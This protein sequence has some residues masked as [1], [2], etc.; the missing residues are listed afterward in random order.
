MVEGVSEPQPGTTLGVVRYRV[1]RLRTDLITPG[2]DAPA[3]LRFAP[4]GDVSLQLEF[5]QFENVSSG[6]AWIGHAIG[7]PDD[8]ST[9]FIV[10][11]DGVVTGNVRHVTGQWHLRTAANG[12]YVVEEL[13]LAAFPH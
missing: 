3:A 1:V 10:G 11:R 4:F 9:T 13:D 7:Q 2:H 6:T 5:E 12:D 8:R